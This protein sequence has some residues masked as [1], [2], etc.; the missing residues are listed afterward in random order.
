MQK[1]KN[2]KKN[3]ILKRIQAFYK[4]GCLST[5]STTIFSF[6]EPKFY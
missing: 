4:K 1:H 6:L 5:N 2:T 3:A